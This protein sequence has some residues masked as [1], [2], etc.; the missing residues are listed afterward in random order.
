MSCLSV[1]VV[2][3]TYCKHKLSAGPIRIV[4]SYSGGVNLFNELP[5]EIKRIND[6]FKF[7]IAV[8]N[9]FANLNY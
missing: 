7:K 2:T 9:H 1:H 8:K 6:P 4:H 5:E 3:Y